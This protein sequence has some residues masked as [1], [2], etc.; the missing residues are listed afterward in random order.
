M[1]PFTSGHTRP[2]RQCHHSH[3]C[4][5]CHHNHSGSQLQ[6]HCMRLKAVQP[7]QH[8]STFMQLN[9]THHNANT[10][11]HK[12]HQFSRQLSLNCIQTSLRTD[13]DTKIEPTQ[14]ISSTHEFL[15]ISPFFL[16]TQVC[17]SQISQI[18]S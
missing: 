16:Q 12:A 5:Q 18:F 17:P 3:Q 9:T 15:N 10:N 6:Y 8:K 1:L 14:A 4:H 11:R 13:T 2:L 7:L